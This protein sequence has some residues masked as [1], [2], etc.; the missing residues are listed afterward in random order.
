MKS[1]GSILVGLSALLPIILGKIPSRPLRYYLASM[2]IHG[3]LSAL[4][5]AYVPVSSQ[6]YGFEWYVARIVQ[7]AFAA[8]YTVE[9]L[10]RF[11]P[12]GGIIIMVCLGLMFG[13]TAWPSI[14]FNWLAWAY[15][16]GLFVLGT[17]VVSVPERISRIIG[18]YWILAGCWNFLFMRLSMDPQSVVWKANWYV[19]SALSVVAFLALAAIGASVSVANQ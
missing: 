12:R 17:I 16:F 4:L 11:K 10:N 7:L 8:G 5:L 9:I 1:L 3:F 15:A 19:P 14:W 2:S 13:A 18:T 6:T